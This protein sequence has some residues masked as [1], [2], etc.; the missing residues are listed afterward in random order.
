MAISLEPLLVLDPL[1]QDA[2]QQAERLQRLAQVVAGG[3][4]EARLSEI[5]MLRHKL[6]GLQRLARPLALGDVVDRHQDLPRGRGLLSNLRRAQQ[7]R[8]HSP[9]RQIDIDFVIVNDALFAAEAVEETAQRR[10]IEA[11]VV[12]GVELP[13]HGLLRIDRKGGV[14]GA[15]RRD[16]VKRFVKHYKRLANGVDDAV[17]IGPRR[18]H[19]PLGGFSLGYIGKG[20]YDPLNLGVLGAVRQNATGIPPSIIGLDLAV[21]RHVAGESLRGVGEEV[22]VVDQAGEVGQRP[23]D[24]RS[25]DAEHRFCGRC[26]QSD[27]EVTVQEQHRN[28]RAVHGVLQIVG[29]GAL[30][31]D[32][33]VELT[34][35]G[36]E[37]LV[38]RLQLF[39]GSFQFFVGR[40]EFF[41]DRQGLFV[42]GRQFVISCLK[43]VDCALQFL[44]GG[45]ELLLELENMRRLGGLGLIL[46][47]FL[48]FR[49]IREADQK[50]LLALGLKRLYRDADPDGVAVPA[51]LRS[52]DHDRRMLLVGLADCRPQ[53][54]A[55]PVAR[56]G[57]EIPAGLAG[58]HL[59]IAVDRPEIIE[60]LVPGVGQDRG[61]RMGVEQRLSGEVGGLGARRGGPRRARGR[62]RRS[63][64]LAGHDG[65][66]DFAR[67]AAAEMPKNPLLFGDRFEP[68]GEVADRFGGAENEDSALAQRE[69]E[70]REDLLLHLGTQ[71]DQDVAAGYEVEARERR[72]GQKI[73][74]REYHRFAQLARH[75]VAMILLGEETIETRRRDI[76]SDRLRIEPVTGDRDGIIVDV[77]CK[78]LQLHLSLRG[79]DLLKKEH[80]ERVGLLARAAP[81]VPDAD[82]SVDRLPADQF[83]NDALRQKSERLSVA[84]KSGDVDQHGLGEETDLFRIVPDR[85]PINVNILDRRHRHPPFDLAPE[86]AFLIEGKVV[87]GMRP[88]KVDDLCEPGSGAVVRRRFCAV[89]LG[90][91]PLAVFDERPRNL[92]DRKH[93]IHGAGHDGAARH[94][95]VSRILRI[96]HDD[97]PAPVVDRR[98]PEAAVGARAREDRA[99]GSL[100]AVFGER[101]QEEVERHAR[102]VPLARLREPKYAGADRKIE[103][104]R[105]DIDMIA[106]DRHALR[107]FPHRHRRVGGQQG[108]HHALVRRI[109]VLDQDEG[110]AGV[111]RERL[112]ELAERLQSPGRGAETDHH[113]VVLPGRGLLLWRSVLVRPL[114]AAAVLPRARFSRHRFLLSACPS[115]SHGHGRT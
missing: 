76:L 102:A 70:Q 39:L 100:A 110:H 14:E 104:R 22:G 81:G 113:K 115:A 111:G 75:A 67:P 55:Q 48:A 37:F 5:G 108:G 90:V 35:E 36:G 60:A 73:L 94:A 32:R 53:L 29:G 88:E 71:V 78:D 38:E 33:F 98:Q 101:A 1:P 69:M 24:I 27:L 84:E 52:A 68:V 40:L 74:R 31:L 86:R 51:Q 112:E 28:L 56:R 72:I 10:D 11:A 89:A 66:L 42:G 99:D 17:G 47:A 23:A 95:V 7:Q 54:C 85:V 21:R 50:K 109:E 6:G 46:A 107:R 87:R 43:V 15:A 59:Q 63:P 93:E 106:L 18:F 82:R 34:V 19:C 2:P 80:G 79:F 25:E 62:M 20:D 45:V 64:A 103:P 57:E 44:A 58:G 3:G 61:R 96:L 41:V 97:E 30:P 91:R 49:L 83:G 77:R 4:E 8:P 13:A 105:D 12:D 65:E 92:V 26:E 9:R 16:D 114:A